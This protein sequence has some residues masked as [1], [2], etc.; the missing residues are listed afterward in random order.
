MTISNDQLLD[1]IK[2][3]IVEIEELNKNTSLTTSDRHDLKRA[4]YTYSELFAEVKKGRLD[5]DVLYENI[6]SYLYMLQ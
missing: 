4:I 1:L 5:P 2:S 6:T 3:Y